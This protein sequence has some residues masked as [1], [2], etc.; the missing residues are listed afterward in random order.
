MMRIQKQIVLAE[1]SRN[2][3]IFGDSIKGTYDLKELI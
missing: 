3:C 2:N 1:H